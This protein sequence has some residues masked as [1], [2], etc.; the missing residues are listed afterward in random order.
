MEKLIYEARPYFY[1]A[2]SFYALVMSHNSPLM[3]ACGLALGVCC[4][5]IIS[6]RSGYRAQAA[7][8][9]RR[10]QQIKRKR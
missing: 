3:I 9:S 1:G 5:L 10:M 2:L 7:I 4:A 6:R 8:I